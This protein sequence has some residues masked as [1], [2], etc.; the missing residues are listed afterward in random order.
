MSGS[1]VI[2]RPAAIST[3]SIGNGP[4]PIPSPSSTAWRVTKKWSN[5]L[6]GPPARWE[7]PAVSSQSAQSPGRVSLESQTTASTSAGVRIGQRS[8]RAG[9]MMSVSVL[10]ST[11]MA[12]CWGQEPS[13]ASPRRIARS[14]PP[15]SSSCTE[16]TVDTATSRSVC[17]WWKRSSRGISQR[18]AKLVGALTRRIRR[19]LGCPHASAAEVRRSKAR[20]TSVANTAA[21]GV[22][23]MRR[24]DLM[25]SRWPNQPSSAAIW[26]LTAPWVSPSSSAASA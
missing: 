3:S 23:T 16:D 18:M 7:R 8:K 6:R 21:T 4:M 12:R 25:N 13:R 20:V 10:V 24:P 5:I 9:L 22:A 19:T 15:R 14:K 11:G 26:R 2:K 1:G 17:A